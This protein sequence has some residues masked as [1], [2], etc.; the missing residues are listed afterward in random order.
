MIKMFNECC[1]CAAPSYPC[2]GRVC[3]NRHVNEIEED[4]LCED[5]REED[6]YDKTGI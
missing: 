1:G 6:S 2:L 4:G 5:C 3:P